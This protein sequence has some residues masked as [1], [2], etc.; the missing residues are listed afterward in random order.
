VSLKGDILK[1]TRKEIQE[2]KPSIY[3]ALL[4]ALTGCSA[5]VEFTPEPNVPRYEPAPQVTVGDKLP[6][7]QAREMGKVRA[8]LGGYESERECERVIGEKGRTMGA[9]YV[10]VVDHGREVKS[11]SWSAPWCLGIAYKLGRSQDDGF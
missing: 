7:G 6:P 10:R 3:I 5:S 8:S 9:N 11:G 2:M 4:L 1:E